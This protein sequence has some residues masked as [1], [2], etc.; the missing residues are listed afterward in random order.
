MVKK[1]ISQ[2]WGVLCLPL[3]C[4]VYGA[5]A[6]ISW[7]QLSRTEKK[8]HWEAQMKKP[9]EEGI[10]KLLS[11]KK[12]Q[13]KP[14]DWKQDDGIALIHQLAIKDDKNLMELLLKNNQK[15]AI[16]AYTKK[17]QTALH[18]AAIHNRTKIIQSLVK[19]K[20]KW[21]QGDKALRV[22]A[23]EKGMFPIDYAKEKSHTGI[24]KMLKIIHI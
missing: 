19:Y 1:K 12:G 10:K 8:N 6:N 23:D 21:T 24:I 9:T 4:P 2:G 11:A 18:L 14:V 15:V 3:L 17:K 20:K 13:P 5:E 16:N 22:L 7:E